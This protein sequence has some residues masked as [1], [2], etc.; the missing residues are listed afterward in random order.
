[1]RLHF[2][3]IG[4]LALLCAPAHAQIKRLDYARQCA[5]EIEPL[6]AFNCMDGGPGNEVTEL[7]ILVNG[8]P[9]KHHVDKCDNPVQLELKGGQG[10]CV[11]FSRLV[12]L[13]SV[14]SSVIALALCREHLDHG[15][16]DEEIATSS[17]FDDIAVIQHDRA[18]GRTCFF[19]STF[20]HPD[21]PINTALLPPDAR[22]VFRE[23]DARETLPDPAKDT[24]AASKFWAESPEVIT[25]GCTSC[26]A[27]DP[28]F[29]SPYVAPVLDRLELN[30]D[31]RYDSNFANLFPSR[32]RTFKPRLPLPLDAR[33][34]CVTCHRFGVGPNAGFCRT[35]I[36]KFVDQRA[37]A[38]DPDEIW[39]PPNF[40]RD[41]KAP[42]LS[43]E[44]K[45]KAREKEREDWNKAFAA[46][47]AQ[48]ESCCDDPEQAACRS[49]AA[50]GRFPRT[51]TAQ[52]LRAT[53]A[54]CNAAGC[55]GWLRLDNNRTTRALAASDLTLYQLRE[56]GEIF[57]STGSPCSGAFCLE[58]WTPLDLNPLTTAIAAGAGVLHQLR[59][60][61]T[62]W[63]FSGTPC[64]RAT[65]SGWVQLGDEKKT[66]AIAMGG[67]GLS[68]LDRDGAVW[69]FVGPVCGKNGCT[70]WQRLD[71]NPATVAIAAAPEALYQ[72]HNS[73]VVRRYLG[74]PCTASGCNGWQV[75]DDSA[76]TIAIA[77][78]GSQLYQVRSD[79]SVLR[80]NGNACNADGCPG[81][82]LLDR[83]P[84]EK[85]PKAVAI[86]AAGSNLY[87]LQDD[88]T[89]WRHNGKVCGDEG[90]PGW[91][92][93][94]KDSGTTMIVAGGDR[95]YQLRQERATERR[96]ELRQRPR[97][98]AAAR[99]P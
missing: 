62:I 86:A 79:G 28:L 39:M 75:I 95:L 74:K 66:V 38:T 24:E 49:D 16:T 91:V 2:V 36:A 76:A 64:N 23:H 47:R 31:G 6:P 21:N 98:M 13:K 11:P 26:H 10:Q 56:T 43:E 32:A 61:E 73:G 57:R 30:P 27:A 60:N 90:C 85:A 94:D 54:A 82:R 25:I 14:K 12:K 42:N 3:M 96:A 55:P 4:L 5:D 63:R 48:I 51:E 59:R 7:P 88:G 19:Q 84:D 18:T 81:W 22:L 68:R 87:K 8:K 41:S 99:Q 44:S 37:H 45:Q 72:L 65:C 17:L 46:S 71:D 92:Q 15:K 20:D 89:V 83:Q 35:F 80:F 78:A 34:E 97:G 77:A 40:S 52:V 9:V 93:L 53:G 33:N 1:M 70:G 67:I 69:R 29:W 50:D 58:G